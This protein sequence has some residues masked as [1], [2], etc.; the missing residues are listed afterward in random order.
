MTEVTTLPPVHHDAQAARIARWGALYHARNVM[1]QLRSWWMSLFA[2][3][4]LEPLL[5]VLALGVGLGVVV[6]AASPGALGV[7]FLQFVAP[8]LLLSIAL[9]AAQ[10]EN[11]LPV[12]NGFHWN[13]LYQAAASTPIRP[14]QLAR[15]HWLGST[16]R[17]V[18]NCCTVLAVLLIFG[19]VTP[20]GAL[21]LLPV[22]VLTAW[23]FG[24]PV[25][26]WT[27]C[28]SQDNGKFAV[29]GRLV[30]LPLTL[31]SGTYF[32]LDVLP[33]WL[34]PI[35]WVSPL[36]HGV[37][38]A[39]IWTLGQAAPAW[40]PVVHIAYLTALTVGGLLAA[41]RIFRLRLIGE[42]PRPRRERREH[43]KRQTTE[44]AVTPWEEL[45]DGQVLLR[46]PRTSPSFLIVAARGLKAGWGANSLLMASGA[47]EPMLYL[48][49][50]GLGLGTLVGQVGPGVSYA[51]WIAPA[52]LASSAMMGAVFDATWNVFVKLRLEKL[53]ETMLS[54][55]LG[56]LDVALGEITVALVRGGSYAVSFIAVMAVLG[57][58]GSWW[59]LLAVPVCL[60][61]ALGIAAIAMAATSFCRT[62]QQM[63]WLTLALMPMFMFSGTFY[64]VD[65]YP[66]PIAVAVK[67]LPLWHGIEMLRDLNMGSVGWATAGHALYFVVLAA[68]GVWVASARLKAL[69]LR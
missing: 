61:I 2:I 40:L 43:A 17:Y 55:S 29:F 69:F 9:H 59:V 66:E 54:T 44:P 34:H 60:L 49:A 20:V 58:A 39:R 36:W 63:D 5:T 27:A 35:G 51:A 18:I 15:G 4:T 47:V 6:D 32:P 50:M 52:L 45:P 16:V 1:T 64:P 41:Q 25:M 8:A 62:F 23:A 11:I 26:A 28:Q 24:N 22:A 46:R 31:F 10:M 12:H 13:E 37:N 67:C 30:A 53:Y 33:G 21:I 38:L 19:A 57:L 68:L 3:G 14:A 7:P 56:P 48:L 65:V 42:L